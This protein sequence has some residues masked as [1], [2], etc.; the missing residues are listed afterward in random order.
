MK[1][2]IEQIKSELVSIESDIEPFIES[3]TWIIHKEREQFPLANVHNIYNG[4][5]D[6]EIQKLSSDIDR[7]IP[8]VLKEF[9]KEANG[10]SLFYNSIGIRGYLGKRDSLQPISLEYGN[11][12]DRP[13]ENNEFVDNSN[14][15]RFGSYTIEEVD[16]MMCLDSDVVYAVRR[17]RDEPIYFKWP[18][19]EEFLLSEVKR[20]AEEYIS[21]NKNIG[22]LEP[23]S[24]PF[25]IEAN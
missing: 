20:M 7:K 5:S 24:L 22:P 21:K 10:L 25:N 3:N 18:N 8:L 16:L 1:S 13:I 19:F 11:I 14:Q 12:I 23:L 15:I 17:F 4:L 6:V 2:L 9:Y